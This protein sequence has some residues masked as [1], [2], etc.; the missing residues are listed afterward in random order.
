[1]HEEGHLVKGSRKE[2]VAD[3]YA[4]DRYVKKGYPLSESVFALSKV[5][6]MNNPEH[7][8]RVYW[9]LERAKE[10]DYYER[11]NLRA[12]DGIN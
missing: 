5:L 7:Y 4:F 11:G 8:W 10:Y 9:Q 1:M 3:K 12:Y 6:S 2:S